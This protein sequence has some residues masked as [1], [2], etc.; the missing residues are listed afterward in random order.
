MRIASLLPAATESLCCIDA[1]D[2]L[3][4]RSHE[5]DYPPTITHLPV[6]TKPLITA[7]T[8]HEIDTQ[9][10]SAMA[11]H[12]PLY[13][14]DEQLLGD[15]APDI[16][17]TQDL[18]HVCSIDLAAVQRIAAT[19]P[20]KPRVI[21]LNPQTFEAV[22]DDLLTLGQAI[23]RE[24]QA[25]ATITNLRNRVYSA[26]EFVNPFAAGESVAMLE[27]TDPIF[28]G[29]HWTPQLI[30]RAG[31]LHPLNPTQ[32]VKGAGAAQGPIGMTQ[33]QAGKSIAIPPEVLVASQPDAILIAP[34]GRSLAQARNDVLELS[35]SPWWPTL[36]AVR[37]GR[38][39]LADGN[40]FFNRPGPRLVD[41]LEFLVGWLHNRP[42]LIPPGFL[43]EKWP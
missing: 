43:W 5:C 38:V 10:R 15:L 35:K 37:T 27:W 3:I 13:T 33:R 18:C 34:C 11:G 24:P 41:A 28:I 39:A 25:L 7:T 21:A 26:Q 29:G 16:I 31:A 42:A 23:G 6:L 12:Q 9:A 14:L 2:L 30:E 4:A 8:P 19:L 36:K 40:H 32:P 1:A 22:L 20:T 17:V